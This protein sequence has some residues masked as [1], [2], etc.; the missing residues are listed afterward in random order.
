MIVEDHA[1]SLD[2][3]GVRLLGI[4]SANARRMSQLI[5]DLLRLSRLG[6]SEIRLASIDMAAL[7]RTAFE[8]VIGDPGARERIDFRVG[9]LPRV[10]GDPAMLRQAWI[11]LLSNAVKFS[12]ARERAVVEVEGRVEGGA[13]VFSVKD[14][15]AGFNA[16]YSAKLFGVFQRLHGPN[17]F[18]GTGVGLA[19]VKRI[20]LRHGG[21]VWAEGAVGQGA[22]FSFSLP[23]A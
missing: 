8:D 10:E 14:N 16:A 4:V 21:R 19:L 20:V 12:A 18:E 15:G 22:T 5:D 11:N 13:A 2:T 17:E 9:E 3:E 1:G 6:R 7:A 23:V